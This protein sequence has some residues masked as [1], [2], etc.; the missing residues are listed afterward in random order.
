MEP[1]A[2]WPITSARTLQYCTRTCTELER[3]EMSEMFDTTATDE[4]SVD[5][6]YAESL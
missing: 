2:L 3:S 4:R 5:G 1:S 6:L